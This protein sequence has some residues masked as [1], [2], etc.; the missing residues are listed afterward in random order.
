MNG[1]MG[2]G[3]TPEMIGKLTPIQVMCMACKKPPSLNSCEL[4]DQMKAA[5]E[6]EE[7]WR[8]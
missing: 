1:G 7:A 4:D 8:K 6:A 3:W 2:P 5:R